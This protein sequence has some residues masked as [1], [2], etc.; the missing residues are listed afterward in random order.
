M[1]RFAADARVFAGSSDGWTFMVHDNVCKKINE[2]FA[3]SAGEVVQYNAELH[4]KDYSWQEREDRKKK[5]HKRA[6]VDL[7]TEN[8]SAEK[9][10]GGK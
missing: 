4:K 9:S 5:G 2:H 3:G 7:D 6:D 10:G 1:W 8:A